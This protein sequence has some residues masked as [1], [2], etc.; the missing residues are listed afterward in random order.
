MIPYGYTSIDNLILNLR[1]SIQ[2]TNLSFKIFLVHGIS[3]IKIPNPE[4]LN[5]I[6]HTRQLNFLLLLLINDLLLLIR[7]RT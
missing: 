1:I 3:L 4:S 6:D 5:A 7:F 2:I